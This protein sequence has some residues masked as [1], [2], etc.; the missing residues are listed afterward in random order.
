LQGDQASN[1]VMPTPRAGAPVGWLPVADNRRCLKRLAAHAI[2]GLAFGV[3]EGVF[4][5]GLAAS[6]HGFF[7]VT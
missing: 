1:G 4:T 2:A 5:F 3:A 6:G 7:S